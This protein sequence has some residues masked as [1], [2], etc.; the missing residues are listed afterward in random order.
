M[1]TFLPFWRPWEFFL[2][3]DRPWGQLSYDDRSFIVLTETKFRTLETIEKVPG[4]RQQFCAFGPDTTAFCAFGPDTTFYHHPQSRGITGLLDMKRLLFALSL[5]RRTGHNVNPQPFDWLYLPRSLLLTIAFSKRYLC[6]GLCRTLGEK[7]VPP[8]RGGGGRAAQACPCSQMAVQ[9]LSRDRMREQMPQM[10]R[11]KRTRQ[12]CLVLLCPG[13]STTL[14][15]DGSW[16]TM[17]F[18]TLPWT[19]TAGLLSAAAGTPTILASR[20]ACNAVNATAFTVRG[21]A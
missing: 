15:A 20:T 5:A 4:C 19:A 12:G 8:H 11:M 13:W 21:N 6:V 18:E 1:R 17:L 16:W 3:V 10:Q 7:A 2:V 14:C 9:L